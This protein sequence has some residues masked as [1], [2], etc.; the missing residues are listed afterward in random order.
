MPLQLR[1]PPMPVLGVGS[2]SQN[3]SYAVPLRAVYT[4]LQDQ[5]G[6][7]HW[8]AVMLMPVC[9][10]VCATPLHAVGAHVGRGGRVPARGGVPAGPWRACDGDGHLP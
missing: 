9:M 5:Q 1:G 7:T 2:G 3:A 8:A 6:A 4:L 10:P